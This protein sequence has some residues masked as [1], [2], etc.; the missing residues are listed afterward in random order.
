MPI[1]ENDIR[2]LALAEGAAFAGALHRDEAHRALA[3]AVTELASWQQAGH[4]GEMRYMQRDPG[5]FA[6]LDSVVPAARSVVT[7]LFP[8]ARAI[9][10]QERPTGFG[11]VARYAWGRDYHAVLRDRLRSF[12]HS[13][14]RFVG[15][16]IRW[17]GFTDA[18]PILERTIANGS[19]LG[20]I[21]KNTLLIRA[22]GGSYYFI[23]EVVWDVEFSS[24]PHDMSIAKWLRRGEKPGAGCGSCLRC[25]TSC[26]TNA[27]P[28]PGK[29][30]A[31]RCISYLTIEKR[32]ALSATEQAMIG[33]W[34]FGCDVCQEVCP[35]NHDQPELLP[36]A[37][38]S[39]EA[40]AGPYLDL[41]TILELASP[42]DFKSR[43]RGTALER[44]G[45]EGLVRNACAVAANTAFLPGIDP[46]IARAEFDTSAIIRAQAQEALRSLA[47]HATSEQRNR[48]NRC[49]LPTQET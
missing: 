43:F 19:G 33:D 4:A 11:R 9:E 23:A 8:Y 27:F 21:G 18:V 24:S 48:I 3:P 31:R 38:F 28:E 34:V 44:T 32:G 14:E 6:T 16:A 39:A 13:A 37:E 5:I 42:A 2:A 45:Y 25:L 10:P 30:D 29:L 49:L 47:P 7:L 46:L 36:L 35:F 26:P 15:R 17:R 12:V 40:G 22:G 1:D 20:F 41:S